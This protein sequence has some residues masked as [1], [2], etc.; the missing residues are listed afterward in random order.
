MRSLSLSW[1][2]QHL[3]V[4]SDYIYSLR[5]NICYARAQF[6]NKSIFINLVASNIDDVNKKKTKL[7]S[8]HSNDLVSMELLVTMYRDLRR[9]TIG[10]LW[11]TYG[12][13]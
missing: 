7:F 6:F 10:N 13:F 9:N 5:F 12:H 8:V 11:Q 3:K 1:L 4:A 2:K